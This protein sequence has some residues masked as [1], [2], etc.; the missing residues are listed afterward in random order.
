MVSICAAQA[1]ELLPNAGSE[2]PVWTDGPVRVQRDTQQYERVE[3][4]YDPDFLKFRIRTSVK[5]HDASSFSYDGKTYVLS[6]VIGAD[7]KR[8]CRNDA[9]AVFACG[10]QSRAYLRKMITGG[11]LECYAWSVARS[12]RLV[13]CRIG[14]RKLGETMVASG[15]ARAAPGSGLGEVEARAIKRRVGLWADPECRA[16]GGC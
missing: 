1:S 14:Q 4:F 13:D 16:A 8:L 5:V 9:G 6:Q 7:P 15:F 10:G 3:G 12:V 2:A 11:Y